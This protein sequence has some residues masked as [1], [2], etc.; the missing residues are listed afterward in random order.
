MKRSSV[1]GFAVSL[2]WS[3]AA[4][5]QTVTGT[6]DGHITDQGGA[7]VAAVQVTAKNLATGVERG[8]TTN[9]TGYYLVT[10]L[11]LGQYQVTASMAGFA[12]VVAEQVDVTLNKTTTV[13]LSLRVSAVKESVTVTDVSPLIDVTSGQVR[14]SLEDTLVTNLP[15]AGR[16]FLS[17]VSIFPGFQ[18][19]PTSGQNNYTLSSGSSVSFNGTGTRGTTFLTDGVSNDDGSENQN[20]QPVNIS[21]I[22]EL[23]VLTN[24]FSPEFGRGFGAVMLVE[25]KSGSNQM[26]GE[27]YWYLQNS[28]LNARSYFANAAGSRLDSTGNLVPNVAKGVSQNHRVGG[29]VG[30]AAIKDRLFYFGSIE[31]Y[32]APGT[33]T[34]TSE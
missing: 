29:T 23:Q 9:E 33:T 16:N 7:V 19:N 6:L 3:G 21:T 24:N 28:A 2:A 26:H 30:G 31:R 32:W 13:N 1:V 12:T 15:S 14:R 10:F 5:A 20:R 34:L 18:T 17:F 8:T 27:A 25:T 4:V 22:K 11:P